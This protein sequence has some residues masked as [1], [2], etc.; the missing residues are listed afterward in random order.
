MDVVNTVLLWLH[1][2]GLAIGGAAA[3]GIP[4][5]GSRMASVAPEMRPTLL[6]LTE[7]LSKVGRGGLGLLIITGPLMIWLKYNGG[8]DVSRRLRVKCR[9]GE[10]GVLLCVFDVES[11]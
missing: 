4:V 6:G 10:R 8:A 7:G 2:L 9:P 5:V 11:P 3:F 1:L